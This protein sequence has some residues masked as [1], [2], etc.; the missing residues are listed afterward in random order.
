MVVGRGKGAL[1]LGAVR[2]LVGFAA[3]DA[4]IAVLAAV[5]AVAVLAVLG[6]VVFSFAKT[7]RGQE[8]QGRD[9]VANIE[10]NDTPDNEH[11]RVL[12]TKLNA[13]DLSIA[14]D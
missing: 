4:A 11:G 7:H 5:G 1:V 13:V 3:L 8:G 9:H 12:I 10:L 6:A 14:E 2:E